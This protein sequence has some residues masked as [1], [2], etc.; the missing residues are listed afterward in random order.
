MGGFTT[1]DDDQSVM[2]TFL[3]QRARIRI[4][5]SR[6]L[7]LLPRMMNMGISEQY[8]HHPPSQVVSNSSS[9]NNKDDKPPYSYATLI[10][11]AITSTDEK[12]MA[13]HEI[14]NYITHHYPYYNMAQNGWQVNITI[15]ITYPMMFTFYTYIELDSTQPFPQQGVCQSTA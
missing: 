7:F 13:L 15:L 8:I 9:N 12:R 10:A 2:L 1:W 11:Q 6:F 5:D 14:Y 4:G 3:F